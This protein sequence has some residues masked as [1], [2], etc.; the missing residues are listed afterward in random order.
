M[1]GRGKSCKALYALHSECDDSDY[2]TSDSTFSCE[3]ASKSWE[4][5]ED[6]LFSGCLAKMNT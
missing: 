2:T 1:W 5:S 6:S 3:D 4:E